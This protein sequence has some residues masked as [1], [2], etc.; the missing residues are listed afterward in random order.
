MTQMNKSALKDA[1]L[2]LEQ[3]PIQDASAHYEAYLKGALLDTRA[4]D[5]TTDR[6]Q[7]Y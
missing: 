4:V 1:L 7:T 5:D 6:A 2:K 3:V